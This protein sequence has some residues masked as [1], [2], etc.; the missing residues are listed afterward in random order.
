MTR[1]RI[2]RLRIAGLAGRAPERAEVEAALRGA[3]ARISPPSSA[4]PPR[5]LA[6]GRTLA[7]AGAALARALG[8]KGDER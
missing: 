7:E 8:G 5:G 1:L 3:L 2:E 4:E 6:G